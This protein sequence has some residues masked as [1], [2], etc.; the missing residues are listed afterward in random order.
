MS[1]KGKNKVC[2]IC[3]DK[4]GGYHF[5]AI[6]CESCKSFF[7]RNAMKSQ[8]EFKCYLGSNCKMNIRDRNGCKRCR[9]EKCFAVGMKTS[10]EQKQM[11]KSMIED[12]RNRKHSV[13]TNSS[14]DS[15]DSDT[16][17]SPQTMC[18]DVSSSSGPSDDDFADILM[19]AKKHEMSVTPIVRPITD[20][21]NQF[22]ELEG[23]RFSELLEATKFAVI[24][25]DYTNTNQIILKNSLDAY[26]VL[27]SKNDFQITNIIKMC[28]CLDTFNML[29]ETDR[30]ILTKHSAMEIEMLRRLMCID[31]ENKYVNIIIN[32]TTYKLHFDLYQNYPFRAKDYI[33]TDNNIY[34][35]FLE[36]MGLDW[37]SDITI[38]DLLTAIVLFNPNRPNL[39]HKH[40]VRHHQNIYLYLLQRYIRMKYRSELLTKGKFQRLMENLNLIF[41]NNEPNGIPP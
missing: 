9:L 23:K 19:I 2:V 12:N 8:D 34:I 10:E 38:V 37:D 1:N 21:S 14:R 17:P 6:T 22:N 3:G 5:N 20:Y 39:V 26:K 25:N 18:N 32:D 28:K 4:S 24:P 15:S 40:M 35:D 27:I 13:A 29:C 11:R 31:F 41:P 30:M 36:T 33:G 7:R 16:S